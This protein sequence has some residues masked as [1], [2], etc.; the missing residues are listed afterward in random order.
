MKSFYAFFEQ[1]E[2][3]AGQ[4][5]NRVSDSLVTT[6]GRH[7]PP[8][9]G[10]KLVLD[11][12][13]DLAKNENADQRFYTSHSQDRKSNP[14]PRDMKLKYLKK[15]FP[16]HADKWDS[17]DNVK[18][19]LQ[20]ASK[21]HKDGYKD[22]H[23]MGGGDRKQDMENLLRKYNGNLYDFDSIFAHSAGNRDELGI[24]D[25]PIAKI[26]ASKQRKAAQNNDLD[27]F[28]EGI[29]THKGFT[30]D[31]AKELFDAVQTFGMKNEEVVYSDEEIR[32]LYTDGYLFNVGDVVESLTNGMIG[33]IHRCGTNHLIVV[34][35]D[36]IMFK[37]FIQD[38]QAV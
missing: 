1:A 35:E 29:L 15:M 5:P 33:E 32:E 26:S 6:F 28:M 13:N 23:F 34:T 27:G 9:I 12:A 4:S 22:L 7:N 31:D 14:L 36:G 11:Q 25:D 17:D 30:E 3:T 16:D 37:S 2:D 38:V 21:A 8:H 20:A 24:E 10:H 19:V 18:T